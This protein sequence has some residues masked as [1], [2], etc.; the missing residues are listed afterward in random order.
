MTGRQ[1]P[2]MEL[3]LGGRRPTN[4]RPFYVMSDLITSVSLLFQLPSRT[5]SSSEVAISDRT[6]HITVPG[7]AVSNCA[8]SPTVDGIRDFRALGLATDSSLE[9]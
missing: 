8:C 7:K 4:I 3:T 6:P 2:S 9:A 1:E 5:G